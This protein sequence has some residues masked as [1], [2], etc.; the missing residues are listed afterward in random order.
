MRNETVTILTVEEAK[1]DLIDFFTTFLTNEKVV[2]RE[3]LKE[4]RMDQLPNFATV[5]TDG[6]IELY[7]SNCV[8]C[9]YDNTVVIENNNTLVVVFKKV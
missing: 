1:E 7:S 5:T 3:M 2:L 6:I 9:K 4:G 8:G